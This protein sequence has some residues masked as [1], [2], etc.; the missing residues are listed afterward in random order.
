[1]NTKKLVEPPESPPA[2]EIPENSQVAD[3]LDKTRGRL[4][5]GQREFYQAIGVKQ[6]TGDNY[7]SNKTPIPVWVAVRAMRQYGEKADLI[8][9]MNMTLPTLPPEA[10]EGGGDALAAQFDQWARGTAVYGSL[11]AEQAQQLHQFINGAAELFATRGLIGAKNHLV[12][13]VKVINDLAKAARSEQSATTT[14]G[15]VKRS[16]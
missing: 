9:W 5:L 12:N 11:E 13:Q 2:K 1:V 7:E 15:G 16:R 8:W 3:W 10:L 6:Q 4:E 14:R